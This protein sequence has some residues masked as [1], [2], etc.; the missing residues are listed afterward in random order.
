[1]YFPGTK[2]QGRYDSMYDASGVIADGGSP[3]LILPQM[4]SRSLLWI[5]N[6]SGHMMF[7]E[8]GPARGKAT[9]SG[10]VV[11]GIAVTNAGFNYYYPPNVYLYGGGMGGNSSYLG[12]GQPGGQAPDQQMGPGRVAKAHCVMTGSA[13]NMS[14]S[15]IVIDDPG[16]GYII[17]P[18]VWL[19]GAH[20]NGLLLDPYGAA[21]PA[22]LVGFPLTPVTGELYING[23][24][25]PTDAVAIWGTTT[26]DPFTCKWMT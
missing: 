25:C 24:T 23:T 5:V 18:Y 1:M 19:G 10:G 14:V 13:P 12:L 3:Q 17:A 4:P 16:Q 21:A 9:I 11:T 22:N 15:S 2:N 8:I 6:L 20:A 7:A 26:S